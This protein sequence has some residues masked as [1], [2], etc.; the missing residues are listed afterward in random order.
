M[1]PDG[2]RLHHSKVMEEA[3]GFASATTLWDGVFGTF[4]YV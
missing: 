3:G 1:E 4:V 2:H